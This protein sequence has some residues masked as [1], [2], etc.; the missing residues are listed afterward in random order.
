MLTYIY[1]YIIFFLIQI[2]HLRFSFLF[3]FSLFLFLRESK[4]RSEID[5]G[6]VYRGKGGEGVLSSEEAFS[7]PMFFFLDEMPC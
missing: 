5:M 2:S 6:A 4:R 7:L 3:L 1:L